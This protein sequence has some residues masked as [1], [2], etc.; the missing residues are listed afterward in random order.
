ML[1]SRRAGGADSRD[2]LYSAR[3]NATTIPQPDDPEETFTCVYD[4]WNR[5]VEVLD[6][7]TPVARY[8]YD[9]LNRR[10]RKL[11]DIDETTDKD[12]TVT[13][14]YYNSNWQTLE[15]RR[16]AEV[17]IWDTDHFV[18]PAVASGV[19]CQYV[20]TQEYI[21]TPLFRDRN[22]DGDSETNTFG[23]SASGLEERICYTTDANHNVTALTHWGGVVRERYM[24]DPYGRVTVLHGSSGMYGDPDIGEESEWDEDEDGTDW[25]NEILY[26]GYRYDP[27]TGLYHVRNRIYDPLTGRWLQR[28]PAGY[29]DG[30]HLYQYGASRPAG[31]VDP[32]GL[33]SRLE[34]RTGAT[35]PPPTGGSSVDNTYV[36]GTTPPPIVHDAGMGPWNSQRLHWW[37]AV[38]PWY[39]NRVF[40]V[41][42]SRATL[43]LGIQG[44]SIN[45][46]DAKKAWQ[47]WAGA[48]GADF[49]FDL[50]KFFRDEPAV[51]RAIIGHELWGAVD[52]AEAL[53]PRFSQGGK[54]AAFDIVSAS[55]S[56]TRRISRDAYPR[57]LNWKAAV[58]SGEV[59]GQATVRARC[60]SSDGRW[61]YRMDLR[62][63]MED[64]FNFNPGESALK[65]L[66]PDEWFGK[67]HLY[68]LTRDFNQRGQVVRSYQWPE[69]ESPVSGGLVPLMPDDG[70]SHPRPGRPLGGRY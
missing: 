44:M 64:R 12:C 57:S 4:A 47:H 59:W 61:Y 45:M 60:R 8:R 36:E 40:N 3:G 2:P 15:E 54:D 11:T 5:L 23:V 25:D 42:L 70:V 10:V 69:G 63:Q 21:D 41:A 32:W 66:L 67:L 50:E 19:Y 38:G 62:V 55:A 13:E 49:G 34:T 39:N 53:R 48:S 58:G 24:Y 6:D 7:S 30:S 14:Y 35:P 37:D 17:T 29:V 46:P 26:C 28:D 9:G 43:D 68:G 18:E 31:A 52:A 33:R 20:W 27:E 65:G 1:T 16:E 22:A 51:G 56:D